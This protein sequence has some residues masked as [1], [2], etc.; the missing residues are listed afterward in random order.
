MGS[1]DPHST[2]ATLATLMIAATVTIVPFMTT[3]P[4]AIARA[5]SLILTLTMATTT[6]TMVTTTNPTT[7]TSTTTELKQAG[8][9]LILLPYLNSLE[10]I[11]TF[12]MC[13]KAG[14]LIC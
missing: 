3:M 13:E 2:A 12:L 14:C 1:T 7:V 8:R 5:T 9:E 4:Q 6:P 11:Q 10:T